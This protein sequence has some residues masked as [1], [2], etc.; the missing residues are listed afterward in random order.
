M[1][2]Q[3]Q[4]YLLSLALYLILFLMRGGIKHLLQ[5]IF[6]FGQL[7]GLEGIY[8]QQ[9]ARGKLP[10]FQSLFQELIQE[11][12]APFQPEQRIDHRQALGQCH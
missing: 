9:F 2:L 5:H 7:S 1:P 4:L 11:D 3:L 8:R 10:A 6:G 12:H